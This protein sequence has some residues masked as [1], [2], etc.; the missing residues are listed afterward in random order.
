MEKFI[1][2]E[3]YNIYL[4]NFNLVLSMKEKPVPLQPLRRYLEK[5]IASKEIR[6]SAEALEATRD[7]VQTLLVRLGNLAKMIA[8]ANKRKTIKKDD[9]EQAFTQY[10]L[11]K[12]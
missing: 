9:I 5:G 2:F 6:I 11:G 7:I 4:K 10:F 1:K 3:L 12:K 8:A